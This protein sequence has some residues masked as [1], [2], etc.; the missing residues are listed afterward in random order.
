MT[1]KKK[2]FVIADHPFAPSGV[3]TQTKY[4]IEA[5]LGTGRY[6]IVCFGGA[7]KHQDYRPQKT[8]E[9]GEDLIIHP[10]DGYG[11]QEQVRSVLWSE[12]PDALWFMTDPRFYG[13]LW[14]M[15]NEIR[16]PVPHF[17]TFSAT[18]FSFNGLRATQIGSFAGF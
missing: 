14:D 18:D 6:K 17:N 15:E 10:I 5:L 11:T 4:I 7:V 9:W 8:E 13:W 2:I 3:G 16:T 1:E 12:K